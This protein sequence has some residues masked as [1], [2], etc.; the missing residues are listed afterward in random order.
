MSIPNSS[1]Y[2]IYELIKPRKII[3]SQT[4]NNPKSNL[5]GAVSYDGRFIETNENTIH[6]TYDTH[7]TCNDINYDKNI[8]KF[9]ELDEIKI[10]KTIYF[11]DKM[12]QTS[13]IVDNVN[14]TKGKVYVNL[15]YLQ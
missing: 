7:L 11:H 4:K 3:N 5:L 13:A 14:A 6:C 12:C 1:T 10:N 8:S 2:F 9:M 15:S